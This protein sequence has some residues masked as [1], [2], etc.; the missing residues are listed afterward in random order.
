MYRF[1]AMILVMYGHLVSVPIY[2][3]EITN[4][5]NGTLSN[6]I[7]PI[8]FIGKFD[9]F[10]L[11]VQTNSGSLG[12]VMF[13]ITSGY[14]ASKMMDR[15]NRK[16]YLVNRAISTFPTLWVSIVVVAIFVY[17]SQGI[18]FTSAEYLST[19][20]PFLPNVSS[21]F[22]ILAI[23]TLRI[24]LKFYLL[25]FLFGKNRKAFVFYGYALLVAL[26][27]IY[28]ELQT[29]WLY[30]QIYDLSYMSFAFLGVLIEQVERER[31]PHGMWYIVICVFINTFIFKISAWFFQDGASRALY[32]YTATQFIPVVLLILLLKVEQR[33]PKA[34]NY[35]P[36]IVDLTGKLFLPIYLTHVGCGIT[37]M[38]QMSLAGFNTYLILLG[39]VA[40]SFVVAGIIYLLVTKPSLN[41]MRK[42]IASMRSKP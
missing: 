20:I 6:P 28:Y 4:V 8:N 25:A 5:I 18:T 39:G 14:L 1:I 13:F 41:L 12:V 15:Y 31:L 30:Q 16:E 34:Y 35:V 36:K 2:S 27:I 23:W 38:Y 22:I 17:L 24:E 11:N 42:V 26:S 40:T 37:V 3:Y 7:L 33:F 32:T 9:L 19:A 29:P 21:S 10:L